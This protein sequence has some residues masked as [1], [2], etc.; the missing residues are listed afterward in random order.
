MK[1]ILSIVLAILMLFGIA[2]AEAGGATQSAET[3]QEST[4]ATLPG[5]FPQAGFSLH[6][7]EAFNN[8]RGV[9][10]PM[11]GTEASPGVYFT[12]LNYLAMSQEDIAALQ[13]KDDTDALTEALGKALAPLCLVLGFKGDRD[14]T[15]FVESVGGAL[16]ENDVVELAKVGDMTFYS[17]TADFDGTLEPGFQEEYEQLS[18]MMADVLAG[19]DYYEPVNLYA[20]TEDTALSFETTDMDGNAVSSAEL[21][22]RH[23]Y[24]LVNIWASWCKPCINELEELQAIH[25]RLADVDCAVVGL[26]Y[27]GNEEQP[28][29]TARAI[30]TEKGV[31]YTVILA[32]ENV[33]NQFVVKAFPTTYIVDRNGVIVGEPIVGAQVDQYEPAIMALLDK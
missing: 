23:E 18:G 9:L 14:I 11:G 3:A 5:D 6:L 29:E 19:A 8:T 25:R 13:E 30:L 31:D 28:R 26:L 4:D 12:M 15:A 10:M 27:D 16:D 22:A 20:G 24:T 2:L 21:F 17:V 33:D 32:P 7:P 1:R